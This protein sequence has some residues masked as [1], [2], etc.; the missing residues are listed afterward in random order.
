MKQTKN[1][2]VSTTLALFGMLVLFPIQGAVGAQGKMAAIATAAE[3][4]TTQSSSPLADNKRTVQESSQ[5][6]ADLARLRPA[7]ITPDDTERALQQMIDREIDRIH[8]KRLD[9]LEAIV[10]ADN[11][12]IEPVDRERR[13]Y[14]VSVTDGQNQR[15]WFSARIPAIW[16]LHQLDPAV[17]TLAESIR[18]RPQAVVLP[19]DTR[20]DTHLLVGGTSAQSMVQPYPG[21]ID[22]DETFLVHAPTPAIAAEALASIIVE[23]VTRTASNPRLEFDALRV[24]PLITQRVEG[25]DYKWPLARI[26]DPEQRTELARQLASLDSGRVN[27]DWR[28][29][30]SGDRYIIIGKIL[31][32]DARSSINGERFFK[33]EPLRLDFQTL[34]FGADVPLTHPEVPLGNYASHMLSR[35][36]YRERKGHYLKMAKR[37]FNFCRAI[38][39]LECMAAVSPIFSTPE[40]R[41]YSSYKVLEAIAKALDPATPS[42]I[43]T[44]D[45]ARKQIL[46]AATI[47]E[48]SLPVVTGTLPGRPKDVADQLRDIATAIQ[49]R[50]VEPV[51]IVEAD[52]ILAESMS[53]LLDVELKFII[54]FSLKDRV[55]NIVETY[56]R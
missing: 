37:T 18:S 33:T 1:T 53:N 41:V 28:T 31:G 42:R 40:S 11:R 2:I 13:I 35:V 15:H 36:N 14:R 49:A 26:R 23:F 54:R 46:A 25:A 16:H 56:I 22:Y 43:L 4:A 24:M 21:D 30:V 47:I 38:A 48:K 17:F 5:Q 6:I 39:D 29:L 7:T 27:T 32:I 8:Q 10:L 52:A 19:P 50:S 9:A 51:G 3:T 44:A 12:A 20:V 45:N 34:Y 55:A